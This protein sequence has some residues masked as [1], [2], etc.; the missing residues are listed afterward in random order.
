L[1]EDDTKRRKED[2]LV[3]DY[4]TI[5]RESSLLTTFAGILFGFLLEIS[6]N[7][8][9]S[10][11]ISDRIVLLI[12]LFSITVAISFFVMPVFYHHVQ[13]PYK[14]LEKFKQRSHRFIIFGLLP[15]ILTLFLG[16]ELALSSIID[17][18]PAFVLAALPFMLVYI[19]FR[20]RK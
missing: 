4:N 13:Y 11:D 16:L 1:S 12:A 19:F 10:F 17:R 15:V 5:L 9:E 2:A 14:D 7:A 3:Q 6:V 18:F 8:P 20:M